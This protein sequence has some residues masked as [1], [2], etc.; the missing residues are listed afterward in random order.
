LK[1]AIP[2]LF[3]AFFKEQSP[4]KVSALIEEARRFNDDWLVWYYRAMINRPDRS[5]VL[6]QAKV[7]VLIVAGDEDLAAPLAD[8]SAQAALPQICHFHLLKETGHMGMLERETAMNE[9]L[10]NFMSTI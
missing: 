5:N 7:P 2:N 4:E 10:L 8:L 1:T 9:I 3:G 6:K